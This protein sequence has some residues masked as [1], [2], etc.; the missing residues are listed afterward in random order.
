MEKYIIK[1]CKTHGETK[2][3]YVPSEQKYRCVK[4]RSEAVQK[5]TL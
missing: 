2:F 5:K 3:V 4:C 1:E